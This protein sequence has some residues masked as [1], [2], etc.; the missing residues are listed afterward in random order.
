[1]QLEGTTVDLDRQ[2]AIQSER[3]RAFRQK[4]LGPLA[5]AETQLQLWRRPL[6]YPRA[7]HPPLP[8]AVGLEISPQPLQ[9]DLN[10]RKPLAQACQGIKTYRGA[11]GGKAGAIPSARSQPGCTNPHTTP[12]QPLIGAQIKGVAHHPAHLA[13]EHGLPVGIDAVEGPIEGPMA[14]A[15]ANGNRPNS[16]CRCA[17]GLG[18]WPVAGLEP[19]LRHLSHPPGPS[20]PAFRAI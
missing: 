12:A 9:A 18:G 14:E 3:C 19:L 16:H 1:M 10:N 13:I 6:A 7:K 2:A 4:H 8:L 17:H 11:G 20:M 5:Q 15:Q